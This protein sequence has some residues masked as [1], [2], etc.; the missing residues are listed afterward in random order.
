M[1]AEEAASAKALGWVLHLACM[2]NSK[3]VRRELEMPQ[4]VREA[5]V[6]P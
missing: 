2:K 1:Q 4:R 5:H 6:W 3:E